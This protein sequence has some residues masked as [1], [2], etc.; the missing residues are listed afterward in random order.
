MPYKCK[1]RSMSQS[2]L[3]AGLLTK[4]IDPARQSL[5]ADDLFEDACFWEEV[6]PEKPHGHTGAAID[7]E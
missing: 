5:E 1:R 4:Y 6:E 2:E 7:V 3:N